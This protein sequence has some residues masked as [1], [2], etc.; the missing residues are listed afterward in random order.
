MESAADL[1]EKKRRNWLLGRLGTRGHWLPR[2]LP[3]LSL[4]G[5]RSIASESTVTLI[6]MGPRWNT[7]DL[8]ILLLLFYCP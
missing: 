2:W 7:I 8:L 6:Q 4:P 5:S 3:R 1:Q